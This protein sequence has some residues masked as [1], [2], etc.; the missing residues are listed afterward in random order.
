MH[1][2]CWKCLS[3]NHA[4]DGSATEACPGCGG[5]YAKVEAAKRLVEACAREMGA[6]RPAP[7]PVHVVAPPPAPQTTAPQATAAP[8]PK[9]TSPLTW[10]IAAIVLAAVLQTVVRDADRVA[11]PRAAASRTR[12]PLPSAPSAV[13]APRDVITTTP[14]ELRA[15]YEANEVRQDAALVGSNVRVQGAVDSVSKDLFDNIVI[16]MATDKMFST[17]GMTI[18]PAQAAIAASLNKGDPVT[19]TCT[20]F[21]YI[22]GSPM[23][24][25]CHLQ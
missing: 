5:I 19:I 14:E 4:A 7:E 20:H 2:T 15:G 6:N 25:K 10:V 11:N 21:H 24:S 12:S 13:T 23:G 1:R 16:H 3:E 18:D 17:V 22:I 9:K 8:A